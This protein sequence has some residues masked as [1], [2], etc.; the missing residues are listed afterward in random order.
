MFGID[1]ALLAWLSSAAATTAAAAPGAMNA[2]SLAADAAP[3]AGSAVSGATRLSDVLG[4]TAKIGTI[5]TSIKG[6][7]GSKERP[8]SSFSTPTSP[9]PVGGA[10]YQPS[11]PLFAAAL[12][13]SDASL[14]LAELDR[15]KG[16]FT[17]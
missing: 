16:G 5:G 6:L 15:R 10:P 13:P 7:L 14:R 9:K 12:P 11:A 2:A 4:N 8:L 17:W 1:D 3:A